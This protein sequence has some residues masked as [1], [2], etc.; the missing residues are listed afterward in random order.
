MISPDYYDHP[1][2]NPLKFKLETPEMT[3]LQNF[4]LQLLWTGC[5]GAY[6]LGGSR[7]GKSYAIEI[8]IQWQRLVLRNGKPVPSLYFSVP[9][10]DTGTIASL[11][12]NLCDSAGLDTKSRTTGSA[13]M[14]RFLTFMIDTAVEQKAEY[15]ILFVDQMNRLNIKQLNAFAHLYDIMWHAKINLMTI[16]IGNTYDCDHLLDHIN[17]QENAHL[18][19]RF[20][21]RHFD[22]HGLESVNDVKACLQ[23]CD[24]LRF[25]AENG[26]TYTAF[27]LPDAAKLGW[28]LASLA[29]QLWRI[30]Q[31]YQ[32]TYK[33]PS[34]GMQYFYGTVKTLLVDF[35]PKLD[36]NDVDDRI[37]H[38]CF[39]V[40]GLIPDSVKNNPK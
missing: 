29:S 38:E 13:L 22:F 1:I 18:Y 30:F 14:N 3:R 11:H 37:I 16:F 20:F 36:V 2:F 40:S 33:I 17:Q 24:T 25:P 39:R 8:L 27:F 19:G 28:K 7:Y 23:Q 6:I 35:L 4:L 31:E 10:T 9:E 5:T 26:P 15:F 12:L 21:T 32:K 34:W